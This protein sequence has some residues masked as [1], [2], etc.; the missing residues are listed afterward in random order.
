MT[1]KADLVQK[2]YAI[3]MTMKYED[4][5]YNSYENK[6][7]LSVPVKQLSRIEYSSAEV[8]PESI[9][10]GGQ[11]NVVFNVYNTG[12]TTLYNVKVRFEDE[13]VSGGDAYVGKLESGATGSVDTM[14][15]GE[16]ATMDDGMIKTVISYENDAGEVTE[17]ETEIPL[18][19]TEDI[20]QD[21]LYV[22]E[23]MPQE[24]PNRLPLILGCTAAG[25]VIVIVSVILIVKQRKKKREKKQQ[26]DD[27]ADLLADDGEDKK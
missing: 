24:A 13:T 19:V 5:K 6:T 11:A 10:V 3:D 27:L 15:N 17:V 23:E 14:L 26:E 2:P 20:P 22:P 9:S 12:K 8:L 4:N 25:I 16:A 21:D 7:S 1:A 18:Y